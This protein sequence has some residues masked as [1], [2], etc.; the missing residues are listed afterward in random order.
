MRIIRAAAAR[1][2]LVLSDAAVFY[3]W[4]Q[5]SVTSATRTKPLARRPTGSRVTRNSVGCVT[6][7]TACDQAATTPAR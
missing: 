7:G 6:G 2:G 5:L 3:R 1:T 4:R